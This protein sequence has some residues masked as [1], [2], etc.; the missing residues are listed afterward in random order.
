[1][2][3][4]S[5]SSGDLARPVGSSQELSHPAGSPQE[6]PSGGSRLPVPLPSD[7]RQAREVVR[8]E[9]RRRR[10]QVRRRRRYFV[11]GVMAAAFLIAAAGLGR[12]LFFGGADKE[13]P[14]TVAATRGPAPMLDPPSRPASQPPEAGPSSAAGTFA[15]ATSAGPVAGSAGTVRKYRVAVENG[16]GQDAD[17]F[18]ASVERVFADPRGWPAAGQVR[19]QRVAGQ[20]TADFTIFLAT[21]VTSEQ[22]CATAGLHTAGYSSCRITGKVVINLARWLTGVPDYGAP[23]EDYQH[24]VINHEV[25][26]ELGNGHEACPGPGRPAP[27]MQQQTYGLKGC[28]ANAWPFVDGQRYSGAKVP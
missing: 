21:P 5:G 27:V 14:V 12:L 25:G 19:L 10:E 7:P 17:A 16:S 9:Q 24:Y 4:P 11:A 2:S 15:Y 22:I 26:H 13:A 28:V 23:V 8:A 6:P 3:R 1:M 18:A 20:G